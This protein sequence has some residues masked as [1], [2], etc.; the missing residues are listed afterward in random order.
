VAVAD[1]VVDVIRDG[2]VLDVRP[3]ISADRRY[4]TLELR[5]TLA[6][7]LRPIP[8][9]TTSLGVGTPVAIQTPQLTLQRIRTTVTVPDGG[10][11]VIGGLRQMSEVDVESGIPF[12]SDLPLIGALFTR[13]GR[14]T[15]RQDII[16]VVSARIIDLEEEEDYQ[17]GAGPTQPR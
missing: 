11:F 12:I 13:K 15:V 8:T 4:V 16:I 17:Y 2:I 9:F 14:S 5:P 7:L 1:P 3:T 6:V 10:S